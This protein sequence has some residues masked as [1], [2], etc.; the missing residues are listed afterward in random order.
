MFVEA[1]RAFELSGLYFAARLRQQVIS[2]LALAGEGSGWGRLGV[3]C[4]KLTSF[5]NI[6]S[7][8]DYIECGQ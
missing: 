1:V 5:R 8:P 6:L 4:A 2:P 7:A 3:W